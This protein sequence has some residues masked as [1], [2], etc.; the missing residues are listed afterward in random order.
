MNAVSAFR[1]TISRY[2]CGPSSHTGLR[3][4]LALRTDPLRLPGFDFRRKPDFGVE[5]MI[6]VPDPKQSCP[7][8]HLE[9]YI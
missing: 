5:G 1:T 2:F 6:Y 4:F 7:A 3:T 9:M 8:Q